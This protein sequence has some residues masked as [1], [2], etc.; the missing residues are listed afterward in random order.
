MKTLSEASGSM[1]RHSFGTAY[2]LGE[3]DPEEST[4]LSSR[5]AEDPKWNKL[6]P[7]P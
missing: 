3:V 5:I 2:S 6:K 7:W 1:K 4:S